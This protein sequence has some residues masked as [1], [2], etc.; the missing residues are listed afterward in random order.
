M[1]R[2]LLVAAAFLAPVS[3]RAAGTATQADCAALLDRLGGAAGSVA[4]PGGACFFRDVTLGAGKDAWRARIVAIYGDVDALPDA[5]PLRLTGGAW[6]VTLPS[7]LGGAGPIEPAADPDPARDLV[8]TFGMAS[9]GGVVRVDR[10]DLRLGDAAEVTMTAR[11]EGMPEVWPVDPRMAARMRLVALSL[12]VDA[13]GLPAVLVRADA[14]PDAAAMAP[15]LDALDRGAP[16][17]AA[18]TARAVV[19]AMPHPKGRLSID[20]DGRGVPL[21]AAVSL[22]SEGVAPEA[23]ARLAAEADVTVTWTPAAP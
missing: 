19:A 11:L 1:I 12:S 16:A 6:G 20:F 4:T 5:V 14:A 17:G 9:G 13:D 10:F 18:A 15:W 3:A 22:L 8:A 2:A 23:L 7:T 21:L